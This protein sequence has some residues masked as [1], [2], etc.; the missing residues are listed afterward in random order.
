MKKF[1]MLLALM[2]ISSVFAV[3]VG[4]T[5]S[6]CGNSIIE[7]G[8]VCDDGNIVSGD[9]CASDCK[10]S[11]D[12]S[13][14]GHGLLQYFTSGHVFSM[15]PGQGQNDFDNCFGI[16]ESSSNHDKL[17]EFYCDENDKD[18]KDDI[19][20]LDFGAVCFEDSEFGDRCACAKGEELNLQSGQCE[21]V[22][23]EPFC[24]DGN[25]DTEEQCDDGNTVDN[26][27]C[28][29]N[30]TNEPSN[31]VPEFGI[32]AAGLTLAGAGAYLYRKRK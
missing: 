31:D 13:D 17:R 29:A 12:D 27:G 7:G 25:L 16:N 21:S 3:S 15:P 28:S 30:C 5:A 8:E 6:I 26:D 23:S 19:D 1:N 14:D 9:G 11:C 32:I 20:C 22:V 2:L 18:Q 10:D 4:A 24:G